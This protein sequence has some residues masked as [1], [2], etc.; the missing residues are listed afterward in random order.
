MKMGMMPAHPGEFLRAEVIEP[1]R[2]SATK[3]AAV[4]GVRR[5]TLSDLLHGKNTLSPE[6]ALRF[7]KAFDISMDFMLRMQALHDAARMRRRAMDIEV[8]RFH[9]AGD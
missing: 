8:R 7:E 9:R 5:A 1:L 4:L 3:A 2:L 6:M